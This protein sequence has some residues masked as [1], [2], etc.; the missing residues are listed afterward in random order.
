MQIHGRGKEHILRS[1]FYEGSS[2]GKGRVW[3]NIATVRF[4]SGKVAPLT[5]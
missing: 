1:R 3:Q 4:R 5:A 2:I